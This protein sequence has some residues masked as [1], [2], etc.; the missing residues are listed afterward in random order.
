MGYSSGFGTTEKGEL[1]SLD[2]QFDWQLDHSVSPP[3][4][5]GG[6]AGLNSGAYNAITS[7]TVGADEALDV[8]VVGS[9]VPVTEYT[10][11]AAKSGNASGGSLMVVRRDTPTAIT[12]AAGDWYP[13]TGNDYGALW[14]SLADPD[15][16]ELEFV[17]DNDNWSAAQHGIPIFGVDKESSPDKWRGINVDVDGILFTHPTN[18]NH[19]QIEFKNLDYDTG[20][21]TDTRSAFGLL[22]PASGG[23]VAAPGDATNGLDVDVTRVKPDG[24]NTMPSL[25]AVGR[26][27]FVKITDGVDTAD[28]IDSGTYAGVGAYILDGSG[29]PITAFGGG[30]QYTEGDTDATITGTA[31]MFESNTG[32]NLLSVVNNS[33]PLPV[34]DAGGSLTVDQATGTNLHTVVDSGT[35]TTVTTVTNLGASN[36]SAAMADDTANPTIPK[37]QNYGMVYD[38]GDANWDRMRAINA[39]LNTAAPDSGIQ[40]VGLVAQLDDTS[41]TAITEDQFGNLRMDGGRALLAD[42]GGGFPTFGQIATV[43]TSATQMSSGSTNVRKITI[44]ALTTNV[45]TVYIGGSGVTTSTGFPLLP[46]EEKT[47][48]GWMD[49]ASFYGRTATA[50]NQGLAFEYQV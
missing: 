44:K 10:E 19:D 34:G 24:T 14:A 8:N 35:I 40:A 36:P 43:G 1:A 4:W 9:I 25:D 30:T 31:L 26:A 11:D 17:K 16:N 47:W 3:R 32:T 23:G 46:G 15:G 33:T 7:T 50:S 29:N 42:I 12:P 28:V 45:D 2:Q 41:P 18:S 39:T 6:L 13:L 5:V 49:K 48:Q 27:G 38:P 22:L 37:I 21:A 20:G